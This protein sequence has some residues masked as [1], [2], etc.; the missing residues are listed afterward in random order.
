[1]SDDAE[2]VLSSP[3]LRVV[4]GDPADASTW[5]Q[6][7]VQTVNK[8]HLRAEAQLAARK[9]DV[10]SEPIHM[11][12]AAAFHA[13]KRSGQLQQGNYAVFEEG[14]IDIDTVDE[15]PARPTPTE[16]ETS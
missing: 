15:A 1:M 3:K 6:Y 13:L 10:T 11:L 16:A 14:C 9:G 4:I 5:R 12:T 7:V 2:I 8:D